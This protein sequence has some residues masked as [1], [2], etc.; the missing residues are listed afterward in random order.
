MN[1][2]QKLG[3]TRRHTSAEEIFE[4]LKDDIVSLRIRPGAKL[5]EVEIA[6]QYDVSRQPVREAFLRLAGLNLLLIRPQKATLVRKI[7]LQDLKNTRFIR[8]AIEVEVVRVACKL[9]DKTRL[10]PLREN[11]EKQAKAIENN[12]PALLHNL[13]YQFHQL[14]CEAADRS[15]AFSVIAA[16]KAHTDRVCTLELSDVFGMNE[17]LEDHRNIVNAIESQDEE[18]AVALTRHHLSHLD[19]TLFKAC[20]NHANFFEE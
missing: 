7:S 8:A 6:K 12:D 20:E 4:K 9:N 16:Y 19:G 2:Q 5:S 15:Q 1:I 10:M 3:D 14:I 11:L 18:L 17:V 13:D